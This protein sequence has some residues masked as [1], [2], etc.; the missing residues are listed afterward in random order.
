VSEIE[1]YLQ[2]N[3]NHNLTK[4]M[5]TKIQQFLEDTSIQNILKKPQLY[6]LSD[7]SQY[8]FNN[9]ERFIGSFSPTE[10]D[11]LRVRVKTVGIK[12]V[13]IPRNGHLLRFVDVGGERSE[14]RKWIYSFQ[15]A[16]AIMFFVSLS[17]YDQTLFEDETIN[18]MHESL[19]LYHL[20]CTHEWLHSISVFFIIK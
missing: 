13:N 14:R 2:S 12:E 15:D 16:R 4:E 9:L 3:Q 17:E 7:S 5:V 6:N 19:G 11:I 1:L 18:R 20:I 8:L 10:E